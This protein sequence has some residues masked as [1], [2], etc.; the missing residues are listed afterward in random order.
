MRK[1][2]RKQSGKAQPASGRSS[3][4]GTLRKRMSPALRDQPG[5]ARMAARTNLTSTKVRISRDR[6]VGEGTFR[7]AYEATYQNGGRKDQTAVAKQFK[8]YYKVLETQMYDNDFRIADK[9][10]KMAQAWNANGPEGKTILITRGDTAR[11]NGTKYLLEPYIRYFEKFTSN[12]GWVAPKENHPHA[13]KVMMLEAFSHFTYEESGGRLIVC[14]L[15]GHYRYKKWAPRKSRLELTDPA[16]CSQERKFGPTDLGIKGIQSFFCNH[17]CN[18]HCQSKW[19]RPKHPK[20]WFDPTSNT[21]MLNL[22]ATNLLNPVTSS[23]RFNRNLEPIYEY[24]FDLDTIN[25]IT[26]EEDQ[27]IPMKVES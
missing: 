18:K 10:L 5:D 4:T 16:I 2:R 11:I 26:D 9:A 8:P 21:S 15:Q 13:W 1:T 25:E 6:L 14:D 19:R 27:M 12:N 22:S 20:C 24:S 23:A 3:V 7:V 17:V